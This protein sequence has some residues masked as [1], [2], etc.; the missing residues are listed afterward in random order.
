MQEAAPKN[1]KY[2]RNETIL[3]IGRHTKAILGQKLKF[4][5]T[6]Q[7]FFYKSYTVVLNKNPLQKTLNIR[8][9]RPF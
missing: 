1:I 9:M 7:N 6:C 3:K 4:Q 2:T 5:K 8:E